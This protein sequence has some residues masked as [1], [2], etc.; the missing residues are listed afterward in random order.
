MQSFSRIMIPSL[1]NL[2]SC[3]LGKYFLLIESLRYIP[4]EMIENIFDE[5][6]RTRSS[7]SIISEND[8]RRIVKILT[9]Y[10]SDVF[11]T[12][13]CYYITNNL[14][15]LTTDFYLYLLKCVNLNL[16]QLDFSNALERFDYEEKGKFLNIIGQMENIEYL[17]LTYNRLDDEDIRLL[18]A[19][20]RIQGK[21]LCNLH[22]LHLQGTM[23]NFSVIVMRFYILGNHLTSR[24]ARFLKALTSLDT[25]YV[26]LLS[27]HVTELLFSS[28]KYLLIFSIIRKNHYLSRNL[29]IF[30]NVLVRHNLVR[31]K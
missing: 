13:F 16:I 27:P 1:V 31:K 23:I 19:C 14:N 10:H 5:Y 26:S 22:S 21:G 3:V 17:R 20:N 15:F 9:D 29:T 24:S 28:N 25:L 2:A 7:L 6:L 18:T 12:S 11:C 8:L 30:I 4:N